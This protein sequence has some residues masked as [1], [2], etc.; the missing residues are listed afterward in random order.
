MADPP[1]E[2]GAVQLTVAW[3]SPRC[4]DGEVGL[5]GTSAGVTDEVSAVAES[6]TAFV[7]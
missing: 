3:E 5:P 4:A 1:A 6:P 7:A 2:L